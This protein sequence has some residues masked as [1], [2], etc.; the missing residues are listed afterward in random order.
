MFHLVSVGSHL[1]FLVLKLLNFAFGL[2][3]YHL[4]FGD[5]LFF[6]LE[7]ALQCLASCNLFHPYALLLLD[8]LLL[9]RG[10]TL[11]Y[12]HPFLGF[13]PLIFGFLEFSL[14]GLH[15]TE[16]KSDLCVLVV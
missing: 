13:L 14:Q 3:D 16:G 1:T 15:L 2:A 8:L 9:M 10:D 7:C 11:Q 12:V 5:F 6:I 4:Q